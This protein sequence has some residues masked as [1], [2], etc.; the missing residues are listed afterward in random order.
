MGSGLR[1][2]GLLVAAAAAVAVVAAAVVVVADRGAERTGPAFTG[3]A[4]AA[5]AV[6][7]C[8]VLDDSTVRCWGAAGFLGY[9]DSDPLGDDEAPGTLGPVKLDG[10]P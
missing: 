7:T 8:A 9:G 2:S 5:G 4:I 10:P 6:H 3:L 1:A